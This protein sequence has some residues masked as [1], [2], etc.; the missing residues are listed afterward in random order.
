[1]PF[2]LNFQEA[3]KH[4]KNEYLVSLYGNVSTKINVGNYIFVLDST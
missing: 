3:V 1:M 2:H 4:L